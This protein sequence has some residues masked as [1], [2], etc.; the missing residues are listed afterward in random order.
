[1]LG[2]LASLGVAVA[3]VLFARH[4]DGGVLP[5][6]MAMFFVFPLA[7][8][9]FP[10]VIGTFTGSFGRSNITETSPEIMVLLGGWLLLFLPLIQ[11]LIVHYSQL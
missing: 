11:V 6:R 1:M 10:D 4:L 3:I 8:I 7:C 9:W 5:A 2:R